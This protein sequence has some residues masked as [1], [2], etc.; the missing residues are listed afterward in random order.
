[1]DSF[2]YQS[3]KERIASEHGLLFSQRKEIADKVQAH[4]SQ[5]GASIFDVVT[6]LCDLKY[7]TQK[8]LNVERKIICESII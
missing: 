7:L 6:A 8:T 1:M 2:M 4:C 5:E 3:E